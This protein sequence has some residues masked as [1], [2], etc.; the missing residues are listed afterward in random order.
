MAKKHMK[1]GEFMAITLPIAGVCLAAAIALPILGETFS[2]SIDTTMGLGQLHVVDAE[3][4]E[5]WDTNYIDVKYKKRADSR[6]AANKISKEIADE[7]IV[8]LKNEGNA[9][10]LAKNTQVAPFGDGYRSP[11]YGGSGSGN[12]D[13]TK[14]YIFTPAKALKKHFSVNSA[15]ESITLNKDKVASI[16]E[17]T[18]TSGA[19]AGSG[20]FKN[21]FSLLGVPTTEYEGVKTQISGTTAIMFIT[22]GGG[23]ANDIKRDGYEDG[24]RHAL[25]LSKNEK[26]T[27]KYLKD[28]GASKIISI[29]ISSNVMELDV[30]QSGEYATDAILWVGGPGAAGFESMADILVGDVNPSGRTADIYAKDLLKTP[31]LAN[32]G[33]YEYTNAE[34]EW[35]G[36][37]HK[38]HF[39][40]YEEGIYVGYKYYETASSVGAINYESE[41]TYPFGYGLS[42]T[43]FNQEFLSLDVADGVAKAKVRVTNTGSKAGKDVVE[44]Y[45]AAPYTEQDKTNKVEKSTKNL[46]EFAKTEMLEPGKSQELTIEFNV[47]DMASYDYVRDNGDGTKGAYVLRNG[48]YTIYLGKNSHDSWAEK[49]WA[50]IENIAY[51]NANPRQSEKNGQAK[52]DKEGKPTSAPEKADIDQFAK[53]VA[54]T[55]QLQELSDFMNEAGI[56]KLSRE[57]MAG[58]LP[59]APTGSDFQLADKYLAN[60][61]RE[62]RGG[63][64]VE[65]NPETGNVVGSLVYAEKAPEYKDNGLTLSNLRGKGYYDNLWNDILDQ[66]DFSDAKVQEELRDLLYYGAYNTAAFSPVGKQ[67]V[68][69]YDGPQGISSFMAQGLDACAFCSEVV[70]SSTWNVELVRKYGEAIGQEGLTHDVSGWYGPAMNTHRTPFS[71][72]NFE[73]YSEDGVLAG[74]IAASVVSGAADQGFYAF[75]KHFALN[76]QETNRMDG[77]CTWATEQTVRENYLKPFE[78][79]VKEARG[80]VYFTAD[81][82]GTKDYKVMRG[83]TAV[84]TSFNNVGTTMASACAPLLTN[85]LRNEWGFQGEVITDFGPYV[86]YDNMIRSG[87]DYLLNANWGGDKPELSRVF[88]DTESATA[89]SVMRRCVKNMCYTV[90]NSA[91]FNGVAPGSKTYRDIA[92]WR[93]LLGGVDAVFAIGAVGL[94][95][96]NVARF[97]KNKKHPEEETVAE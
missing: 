39:V 97:I 38:G 95:G 21:D 9:L 11:T 23:E 6:E 5:N 94:I 70:V 26:D 16:K 80:K 48:D 65:T 63:Y 40:Q 87:N 76:D 1:N 55:N 44:L 60:W 51:T 93:F 32:F 81:D 85:V 67:K 61:N 41:V 24:T 89:K 19:V 74:K 54:A 33:S 90:V 56:T 15:I 92:P 42:Y 2:V 73:Y 49:K 27:I 77:I 59:T 96:W 86:D 79:V 62:K 71:G 45:Y 66:I 78:I 4:S 13:T 37:Q 84:M 64:D 50:N 75:I 12:V 25:A 22:R 68:N 88:K 36:S 47:E 91:A 57:D 29:I 31:A 46:V 83:T 82:Q 43:T 28:N 10:P 69:D 58:T 30:L 52:L 17:A 72:R 35:S 8:L 3:G 53:F 20:M 34:Y 7:G 14:D 18:G